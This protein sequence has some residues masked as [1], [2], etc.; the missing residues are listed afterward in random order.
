MEKS[1]KFKIGD[2]VIVKPN[3]KDEEL[4]IEVDM[5][6][7]QGRISEILPEKNLICI[8]WDSITL[9]NIPSSAITLSE[10]KGFGWDQ[11][12]LE[13]GDVE[14][15]STRDKKTDVEKICEQLQAEHAWD[16]LGPEGQRIQKVLAGID[17]DDEWKAFKAWNKH[18]RK[19][20][21][22]PFEAE[23]SEFQEQG[24]LKA[25][26][27]VIVEKITDVDDLHGV[28]VRIKHKGIPY[29]FPLCNL[30]A[31]DKKS[32]NYDFIQ[33]YSVWFSNR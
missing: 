11:Y 12:Y 14:L 3:V 23:V 13:I 30:E 25:G 2:S 17:P 18:L 32:P 10:E 27:K 28:I 7:W 8:D 9:K 24:P 1:H 6:G 4:G 20:L 21:Q 29:K 19:V 16:C 26:D 5:G 33:D 15:T 22:F 31:I